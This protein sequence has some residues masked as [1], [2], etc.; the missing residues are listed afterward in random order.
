MTQELIQKI[1]AITFA[2]LRKIGTDDIPKKVALALK[3]AKS[4]TPTQILLDGSSLVAVTVDIATVYSLDCRFLQRDYQGAAVTTEEIQA[5]CIVL[6]EDDVKLCKCTYEVICGQP[7][8]KPTFINAQYWTTT[9][10]ALTENYI[11]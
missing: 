2:A 1:E 4:Q 3:F 6:T 7:F 8:H 10:D 11:C 5:L 9:L